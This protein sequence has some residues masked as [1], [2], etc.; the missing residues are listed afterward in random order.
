VLFELGLEA[1]EERESIGRGAGEPSNHLAVIEPPH[2]ARRALDDDI[3]ER[4]L[5]IT[6]D[7]DLVANGGLAAHADDGGAVKLFHRNKI[8][9]RRDFSSPLTAG[10][11]PAGL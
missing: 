11:C 8:G 9:R 3:A 6:T 10:L 1:L 2:L 4:D 5:P 7:R